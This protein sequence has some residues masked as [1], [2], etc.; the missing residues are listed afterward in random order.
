VAGSAL[1][2]PRGGRF[3]SVRA[4]RAARK[5]TAS[6]RRATSERSSSRVE[7][8]RDPKPVACKTSRQAAVEPGC[9]SLLDLLFYS[10]CVIFWWS[11]MLL[12]WILLAPLVYWVTGV[13]VLS[14]TSIAFRHDDAAAFI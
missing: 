2:A 5:H 7:V 6:P 11:Y 3:Q 8:L 14:C 12:P 13:S 9:L 1:G 10:E 4:W